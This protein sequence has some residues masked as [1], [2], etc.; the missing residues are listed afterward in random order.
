[1]KIESA[2]FSRSGPKRDNQDSVLPLFEVGGAYWAAI[3]D[4][5]GGRVGGA[6]ASRTAIDAI[7]ER[8]ELNP[9]IEIPG[10]FS[11]VHEML[12]AAAQRQPD[13]ETMGTTLSLIHVCQ[14]KGFVGHVGDSRIYH[15]RGDGLLDRTV[16]QTEVEHLIQHG[17]LNKASARRYARRNI[18]LSVL[19][20]AKNYDLHEETFDIAQGDRLIL[21]TDGVS[22]KVLRQEIRN[23]SLQYPNPEE[24]CHALAT[25]VD[26]RAP[27]DDFSAVCL[28]IKSL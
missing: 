7:R 11:F 16:D 12:K 13:L 15:L 8:I 10:L 19:S 25:Q 24:F 4:G 21:V 3:A 17:V 20:P 18:L 28:D 9:E 27:R 1:M 26:E 2:Y 22:S 6:I 23:L 14:E 5:M